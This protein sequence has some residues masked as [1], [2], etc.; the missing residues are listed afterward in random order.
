L[1]LALVR[2]L[3]ERS[4]RTVARLRLVTLLLNVPAAA[5]TVLLRVP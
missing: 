1:I 5:Q 2:E 4:A 3:R